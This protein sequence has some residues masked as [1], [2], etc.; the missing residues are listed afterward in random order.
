M[1]FI[2]RAVNVDGVVV[3]GSV[4]AESHRLAARTLK[5]QGLNVTRL[6]E[7]GAP[8]KSHLFGRRKTRLTT[9]DLTLFVDK[10][11]VLLESGISIDE[12]IDS[13]AES[14]EHYF[15][16]SQT[17]EIGNA[18]RR[19]LSFSE[20]LKKS[21]LKLPSYFHF[22]TQAGE[23]T[24]R[25]AVALRDGLNQW[26]YEIETRKKLI[27]SLTYPVIL[28][29]SGVAAVILI[30]LVVVPRFL[31]ILDKAK[32]EIPFLAQ[33]VLGSGRFFHDHLIQVTLAAAFLVGLIIYLS[34]DE[35]MRR[36]ALDLLSRTP[37]VGSWLQEADVGRWAAMM[38]TLLDNRVELIYALDLASQCLTLGWLQAR[39]NA[40]GKAVRAGTSMSDSLAESQ[41]LSVTGINLVRVGERSGQL[42]AMLRSLAR[43]SDNSVK[44][45][46]EK[47]LAL[48]EPLAIIIIGAVIGVIMAGLILGITSVND[49]GL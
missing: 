26:Q 19:G 47:F 16:K 31:K 11:C 8:A 45:R 24:G 35:K 1:N 12:T 17:E 49:V 9:K 4:K 34:S 22:L 28:V 33:V 14:E 27:N 23:V 37:F 2:Y 5:K 15:L 41:A 36:K 18:L 43:L 3:S 39:F 20:A 48:I 25:L 6:V 21:E 30:F 38:A 29:L 32:T 42:P 7:A 13:L 40:I 10:L 46:T 44:N